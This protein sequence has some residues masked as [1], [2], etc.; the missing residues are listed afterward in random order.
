MEI[1]THTWLE[2]TASKNMLSLHLSE[3][4]APRSLGA[5]PSRD[6]HLNE[7]GKGLA[8]YSQGGREREQEGARE[9]RNYGHTTVTFS[10]SLSLSLN[11]TLNMTNRSGKL[12]LL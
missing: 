10:L 5:C 6:G 1:L 7:R 4:L 2:V 3:I 12:D 8:L 9:R 11:M